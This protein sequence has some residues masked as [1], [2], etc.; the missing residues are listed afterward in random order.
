MR[1]FNSVIE[2]HPS[3]ERFWA[4]MVLMLTAFALLLRLYKLDFSSIWMDE[5]WRLSLA[6]TSKHVLPTTIGYPVF[7]DV[8]LKLLINLTSGSAW[9]LRLFFAICGCV[10][11][12]LTYAL[13]SRVC[14]RFYA[15]LAGGL[16]A[17][18]PLLI[19]YSQEIHQYMPATVLVLVQAIL[20]TRWIKSYSCSYAALFGT[21]SLILANLFPQSIFLTVG[22]LFYVAL[23]TRLR[24]SS[25]KKSFVLCALIF[26]PAIFSFV[27]G[28]IF[29]TIMG[30]S[31]GT[32]AFKFVFLQNV[33]ERVMTGL[34]NIPNTK[35]IYAPSLPEFLAS[36]EIHIRMISGGLFV[37]AAV[38]ALFQ[39]Q[40]VARPIS[41]ALIFFLAGTAVGMIASNQ[42]YERYFIAVQPL[43]VF[44]LIAFTSGMAQR[45][46]V[47]KIPLIMLVVLLM[48]SWGVLAKNSSYGVTWKPSNRESFETMNEHT[49]NVDEAYCVVPY[50]FEWPIAAY[51][52]RDN[53]KIILLDP[54]FKFFGEH[55]P[56]SL[57]L[58]NEDMT[59]LVIQQIEK[60]KN[61]KKNNIFLYTQRGRFMIPALRE[62]MK[63]DYEDELIYDKGNGNLMVMEFKLRANRET[64][65][66]RK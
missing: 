15:F 56:A 23:A 58:S 64:P 5:A 24:N 32:E 13:T 31:S 43:A 59:R 55:L 30:K 28:F 39:R 21:V 51:Y 36:W 63:Q 14:G 40:S 60:L 20:F 53:P 2:K 52:L 33:F 4:L 57:Q 6:A 29:V 47:T 3:E 7:L 35:S 26:S 65:E 16:V 41:V 62:A 11:I 42:Y 34:F 22:F 27:W 49:R 46:P 37:I 50:F 45:F 12:P 66:L 1:I 8:I 38:W 54:A 25:E 17:I 61:D 9:A 19:T 48:V 44:L 10:V 18:S